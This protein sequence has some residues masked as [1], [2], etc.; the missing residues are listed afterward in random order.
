MANGMGFPNT[1]GEVARA[2]GFLEVLRNSS[3]L[4]WH[5]SFQTCPGPARRGL[6]HPRRWPTCF[7]LQ[8]GSRGRLPFASGEAVKVPPPSLALCPRRPD[9]ISSP[10]RPT[11]SRPPNPPG[12]RLD[13]RKHLARPWRG[14]RGQVCTPAQPLWLLKTYGARG[15][16]LLPRTRSLSVSSLLAEAAQLV[17]LGLPP[18]AAPS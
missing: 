10:G 13:K 15:S 5:F 17:F 16:R 7:A 2:Q 18:R 1:P 9:G 6:S 4:P 8:R 11:V 12:P 3:P 14:Y